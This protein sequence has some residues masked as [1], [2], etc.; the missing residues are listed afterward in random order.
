MLSVAKEMG[1]VHT[2][3]QELSAAAQTKPQRIF[4]LTYPHSQSESRLKGRNMSDISFVCAVCTPFRSTLGFRF[5]EHALQ[6]LPW[7][8]MAA[9][10]IA[11][12]QHKCCQ[13]LPSG[14]RLM[15]WTGRMLRSLTGKE[16]G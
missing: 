14:R 10:Q 1:M 15:A 11:M 9:R 6:T 13:G 5:T 4:L 8:R 7:L 3:K 12:A 16:L 2:A